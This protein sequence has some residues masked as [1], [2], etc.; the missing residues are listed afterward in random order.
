M[1]KVRAPSANIHPDGYTVLRPQ[2]HHV[3]Q[4]P[5][6]NEVQRL[7]SKTAN[8]AVALL[9]TF[10]SLIIMEIYI[11]KITR[12]TEH[13]EAMRFLL[14]HDCWAGTICAVHGNR[15]TAIH[16]ARE[17]N[18]KERNREHRLYYTVQK[19]TIRTFEI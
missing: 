5:P 15:K 9:E 18:R 11:L 6:Q 13:K 12:Y 14:P 1:P 4:K 3:R 17:F 10:K 2:L 8:T 16:Y 19:E 7:Q